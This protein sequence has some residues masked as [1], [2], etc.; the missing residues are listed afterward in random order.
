M[1]KVPGFLVSSL[2]W[3]ACLSM[4]AFGLETVHVEAESLSELGGWSIDTSFIPIVGSPYVLAHGLGKPVAD[5]RGKVRI[6]EGGE[7]RVWVRTKDWVAPWKAPGTPGRF[8]LVEGA[9]WHW[10]SGGKVGMKAGENEFA[11]HDLT[12]FDGRCDAIV[13]SND[14]GFTPPEGAALDADRKKR[15]NPDGPEDSGEF[16][17]VVV[18]GGYAG[19]G[20]A[21]S[22]ARQSLRVALIQDRFVLGGNG[23]S[24]IGVWAQGGTMRG[25]FPHIGE[26]VEEFTDHAPDSPGAAEHF[27]D[28]K[29][30]T[31][32]RGEKTLSLFLGH[33]VYGVVQDGPGMFA[34]GVRDVLRGSFSQ[35]ARGTQPWAALQ[36]RILRWRKRDT[37]ECPTCGIG[38]TRT[39]SGPGPRRRGRCRWRMGIFRRLPKAAR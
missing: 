32:C 26:I 27:V 29:K 33:Y 21:I 17:L 12:G 16:D 4:S 34:R 22:A 36:G 7:Y 1:K 38:S 24:E 39:P 31:V 6:Q 5:A 30:E 10:Q 3:G 28:A 25:K 13:L 11:L 35:T 14:P 37:W 23:S 20:A 15:F 8:Q 19:L 9:E 2:V 18:G